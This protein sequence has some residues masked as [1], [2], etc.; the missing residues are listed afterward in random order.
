MRPADQD[1]VDQYFREGYA[2]LPGWLDAAE[3]AV[4]SD[5]CD[6]LLSEPP[7]DDMGGKAHDIG[8]GMDRRFLR[9]RH[10][11]FPDLSAF[12][13]GQKMRDFLVPFIGGT[14]HLFN[15]QFVVK[16]PKTGSAFGWHQ[17]SGYVGFDH[18][19]YISVWISID[20]TTD[21][22]GPV[23]VLPKD[24]RSDISIVPHH[25]DADAKE[26]VGYDGPD[27]GVGAVVPAGSLVLFSSVT[28]HRSSR[29]TTDKARRAYLAQYSAEPLLD[30]ETAQPKTFATAL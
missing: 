3:L 17:D 20:E 2:I 1:A 7:D 8:R 6:A 22:N 25:W 21:E 23:F 5:A 18:K 29:N 11:D 30:P 16:G 4:L 26:M 9:H 10:R 28:L 27:P 24:L 14:P 12:I 13:L 15:E 19:P